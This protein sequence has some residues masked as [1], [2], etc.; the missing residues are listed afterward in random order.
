MMN[1]FCDLKIIN[2]IKLSILGIM[3]VLGLFFKAFIGDYILLLVLVLIEFV[4]RL[5]FKYINSVSYTLSLNSYKNI[6]NILKYLVE[7]Q[8]KDKDKDFDKKD[9]KEDS[10]E[11]DYYASNY[12]EGLVIRDHKTKTYPVNAIV[13]KKVIE[14]NKSNEKTSYVFHINEF[15]Y[16][17]IENGI[18][19]KIKMD[20]SPVIKNERTMLPLRNVAEVLGAEVFW[21]E[22]TRT[23]S[24]TKDGLT[25]SIQIDD[26]KIIL[27]S[28]EVIEMDETKK[29][30][31]DP[32][33]KR[34]EDYITG[35]F[36]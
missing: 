21:N 18:S 30:F 11:D 9:N 6:L 2:Y 36:G 16:E 20:I 13:P 7:A 31:N 15:E 23:A 17:I 8:E 26:N 33:D 5:G 24:F 14:E 10:S 22:K 28:G 29:I 4:F 34:T 25:A 35:R 12:F 3:F 1:T 19:K 32:R 27:S